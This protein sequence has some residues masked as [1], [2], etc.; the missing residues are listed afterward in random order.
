MQA[1]E[2]TKPEAT[3]RRFMLNCIRAIGFMPDVFTSDDKSYYLGHGIG[4]GPLEV[5]LVNSGNSNSCN[6]GPVRYGPV[7]VGCWC[8]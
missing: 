4:A 7:V 1:M 3:T 5:Q 6:S 8:R 2:Y